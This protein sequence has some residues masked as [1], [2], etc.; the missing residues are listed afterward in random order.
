M[1]I[2]DLL[3]ETEQ[4]TLTNCPPAGS[5]VHNWIF[6]CLRI[7]A[8]YYKSDHDLLA[9]MQTLC[10]NHAARH[11]DTGEI[12]RQI[13]SARGHSATGI[14]SR[15]KW[16]ARNEPAI[17]A[18]VKAG[19]DLH[20]LKC[21]S[22][23]DPATIG[24]ADLIDQLFPGNPLLCL[25]ATTGSCRTNPR[26][27][28]RG[29][30]E[31]QQFIIPSPMSS[32]LGTTMDGKRSHR[33]LSNTS[34]RT[35]LVVECDFKPETLAH[36][37]CTGSTFDLCAIVLSDL[38]K[39][40]PTCMVVHS[41][42][43]SL[44]SWHPCSGVPESQLRSFMEYAVSLGADRATW[45]RSQLV[46]MPNGTRDNGARQEV[47]FFNPSCLNLSVHPHFV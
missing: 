33:A 9:A 15:G 36:F 2:K 25:G 5:G 19:G 29:K 1:N 18:L 7:L 43:K 22:P 14:K 34:P 24:T 17:R 12:L 10:A 37:G 46:R 23:V 4:A 42:G 27:W 47:I 28:W 41:G 20:T 6:R 16:P 21:A 38:I 32:V 8:R 44:H 13:A 3:S 31:H 26:A 45:T 11:V 40:L 39:I 35:Y 30:E